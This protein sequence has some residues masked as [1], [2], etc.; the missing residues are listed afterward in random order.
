MPAGAFSRGALPALLLALLPLLPGCEERGPLAPGCATGE[1][2]AVQGSPGARADYE[3][4]LVEQDIV[5]K[6]YQVLTRALARFRPPAPGVPVDVSEVS[7]DGAPLSR[8]DAPAGPAGGIEF[9]LLRTDF[10]DRSAVLTSKTFRGKGGADFATTLCPPVLESPGPSD[11]LP[12][13]AGITVSSS[14]PVES[15]SISVADTTG[16]TRSVSVSAE[17]FALTSYT[18][19][20][21]HLR[22]LAPGRVTL[23]AAATARGDL[24]GP[25]AGSYSI[26]VR[27]ITSFTLEP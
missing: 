10:D 13:R 23:S 26:E 22:G 7:L 3:L 6:R 16:E 9:T 21:E 18:L 14:R 8:S 25:A 1:A 15:L 2:A 12:V 20:P 17:G 19:R 5:D 27:R 11:R 4:D 24:P